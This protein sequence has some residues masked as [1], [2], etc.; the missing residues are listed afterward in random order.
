MK[1]MMIGLLGNCVDAVCQHA[2]WPVGSEYSELIMT[3]LASTIHLSL[4]PDTG[5]S[6]DVDGPHPLG[7]IDLVPADG[8]QIDVVLIDI[9]WDLAY[10]LSCICVEEDLALPTHLANLLCGLNDTCNQ[11]SAIMSMMLLLAARQR[12]SNSLA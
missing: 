12:Q 4:Q 9:D 3:N 2:T 5:P 6:P 10:R 7:P 8:H 1:L 11:W